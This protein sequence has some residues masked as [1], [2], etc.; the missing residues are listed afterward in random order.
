MKYY[1]TFLVAIFSSM[2]VWAQKP[3]S[4]IRFSMADGSPIVITIN[5]RDFQK[6]GTSLTVADLPRKRHNVR[7]YKFRPYSDGKG[8]KAEI[9]YAGTIKIEPGNKYDAVLNPQSGK[10][11]MKTV[12]QFDVLPTP[13][14][15][16]TKQSFVT[17]HNEALYQNAS[18]G[19]NN[20]T[21]TATFELPKNKEENLAKDVLQLK[22]AMQKEMRDGDKLKKAT[23]FIATRKVS[24]AE[25]SAILTWL[26]FDDNKLTF[27]KQV[28]SKLTDPQNAK[29]LA[30]ELTFSSSKEEY[31][32]H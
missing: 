24:T 14:V 7:I 19:L 11:M 10:L 28:K 13:Q 23:Q 18:E 16:P 15:Q 1:I 32:N 21:A 26:N 2:A 22:E 3:K 20:N 25:A 17:E 30:D 12:R 8:G 6:V 31:L 4:T 29:V 27:A 9:V 5:D